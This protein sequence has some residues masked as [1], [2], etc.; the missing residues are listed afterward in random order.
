MKLLAPAITLWFKPDFSCSQGRYAT[1]AFRKGA[2]CH[3]NKQ[4]PYLILKEDYYL[5][6]QL[7]KYPSES[8]SNSLLNTST[9]VLSFLETL[10]IMSTYCFTNIG[11]RYSIY[12][13]HFLFNELLLNVPYFLT[14]F[15]LHKLLCKYSNQPLLLFRVIF[16]CNSPS[17]AYFDCFLLCTNWSQFLLPSK[18]STTLQLL[19]LFFVFVTC[20]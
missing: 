17:L 5:K 6:C 10:Y 2:H 11:L 1:T 14:L 18:P 15:L 4:N 19:F 8:D 3:G 16:F 20:I 13:H 7:F 12:F 9:G